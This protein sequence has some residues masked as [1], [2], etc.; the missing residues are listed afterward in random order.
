MNHSG[1]TE[2]DMDL[3]CEKSEENQRMG[4]RLYIPIFD[5]QVTDR[6]RSTAA[7]E[8]DSVRRLRLS[9]TASGDHQRGREITQMSDMSKNLLQAELEY[10]LKE[11][12]K[13]M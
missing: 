13:I 6:M 4:D 5:C 11:N 9:T 1:L 10:E 2:N 8:L 7:G 3:C 12:R